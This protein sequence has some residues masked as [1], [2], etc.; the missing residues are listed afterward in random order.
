M[1]LLQDAMDSA[2]DMEGM[3]VMLHEKS[4]ASSSGGEDNVAPAEV[5]SLFVCFRFT[6]WM[7]WR[8]DTFSL[9]RMEKSAKGATGEQ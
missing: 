8:G 6:R 3:L 4:A 5:G 1:Q 9:V 7:W 2:A